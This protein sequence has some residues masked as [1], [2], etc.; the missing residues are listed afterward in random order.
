MIK[1]RMKSIGILMILIF[2]TG[3]FSIVYVLESPDYL[4]QLPNRINEL[5]IG[6]GFQLLMVAIYTALIVLIVPLIRNYSED[7]SK[8][9]IVTRSLS[10]AFHLIGIVL[11]MLFIP[12]S[13]ANVVSSHE[14]YKVIGE[15]LRLGRDLTNHIGVI[16]PYLVGSFIFYY[17]LY[18]ENYIYK[19]LI[20]LGYIGISLT[21]LS[22]ILILFNIISVVSPLFIVMSLPLAFQEILLAIVLIF[23]RK[24][25]NGS[26]KEAV[27]IL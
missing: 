3:I 17:V 13:S 1:N 2:V 25:F 10:I 6:G 21:L 15:I 8:Y 9:F 14:T 7:L 5:Y 22:S 23:K 19:W 24:I 27:S 12:L 26:H 16:I 4:E 11:L 20:V 18:K